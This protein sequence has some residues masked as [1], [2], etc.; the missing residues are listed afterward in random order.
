MKLDGLSAH[1]EISLTT[2][3]A[4]WPYQYILAMVNLTHSNCLKAASKIVY[5]LQKCVLV[6]TSFKFKTS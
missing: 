5:Y 1:M 2:Y 6:L 4:A 3:S